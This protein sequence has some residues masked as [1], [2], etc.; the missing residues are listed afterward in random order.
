MET[1]PSDL[2]REH[3]VGALSSMDALALRFTAKAFVEPTAHLHIMIGE[4]ESRRT[5]DLASGFTTWS[6]AKVSTATQYAYGS[7][8]GWPCKAG[9]RVTQRLHQFQAVHIPHT[10]L[11]SAFPLTAIWGPRDT[12]TYA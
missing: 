10:Q 7:D 6:L 1:L 11:P 12:T 2:V 8:S 3:I 5:V 4:V 9:Y